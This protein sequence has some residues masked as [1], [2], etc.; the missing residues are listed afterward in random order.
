MASWSEFC[1]AAVNSRRRLQCTGYLRYKDTKADIKIR[2]AEEK[3][4]Y[5]YVCE[6]MFEFIDGFVYANF[7]YGPS[8]LAHYRIILG[9]FR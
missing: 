4:V 6:D 9:R 3:F 8:G 5:I 2:I 1:P 7:A